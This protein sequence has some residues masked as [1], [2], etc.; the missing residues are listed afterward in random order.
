ML[1][2]LETRFTEQ[3]R[4]VY[5]LVRNLGSSLIYCKTTKSVTAGYLAMLIVMLRDPSSQ[6]TS[7]SV[8]SAIL[9]KTLEYFA[10]VHNVLSMNATSKL[11]AENSQCITKRIEKLLCS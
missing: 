11:E 4:K 8:D 2:I 6:T 9:F 1:E 10:D 5:C 7:S 3:S